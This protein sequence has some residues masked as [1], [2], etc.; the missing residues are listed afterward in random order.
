MPQPEDKSLNESLMPGSN[1][2]I[3]DSYDKEPADEPNAKWKWL[4]ITSL[5]LASVGVL[6]DGSIIAVALPQVSS[7]L[8]LAEHFGWSS[9]AFLLTA[10]VAQPIS[11]RIYSSGYRKQPLLYSVVCYHL[12]SIVCALGNSLVPFIVGRGIAGLGAGSLFV[13]TQAVIV[14]LLSAKDVALCL[15]I[16]ALVSLLFALIVPVI[17]GIVIDLYS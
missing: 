13:G 17:C 6:T 10:C 15:S 4:T 5:C 9:S 12:S 3:E 11:G 8:A 2:F 1:H 14:S 16:F 7:D